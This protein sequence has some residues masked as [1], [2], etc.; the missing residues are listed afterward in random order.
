MPSDQEPPR[1]AKREP[2]GIEVEANETYWWCACGRSSNQPFCDGSHEGTG[3]EP[4]AFEPGESGEVWFCQCKQTSGAPL[5]D[6]SHNA[7]SIP[8]EEAEITGPVIEQRTDGPLVVKNLAL[9]SNADGDAIDTRPVMALCRCGHSGNKPFCDG[10]HKEAGFSSANELDDRKGKVHRYE[11]S[12]ITVSFN[13]LTCSHAAECIRRAP[14][15][16][17]SSE[18]R[19]IRPEKGTEADISEVIMACPSGALAAHLDGSGETHRVG[20]KTIIRIAKN[21]PYEVRNVTLA[22]AEWPDGA[23][24]EKFVLCR[25]GLS[26]NKPF[27]DG[28]HAD[29]NWRDGST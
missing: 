16:F 24:R 2:I 26:K 11:G 5:C 25:C 3:F 28:S 23:C 15:V 12:G 29:E 14:E 13:L 21:G 17:D 18:R 27:C 22:E 19:W 6:G 7:L 20:E 9:L 10:S 8:D 4:L 1:I